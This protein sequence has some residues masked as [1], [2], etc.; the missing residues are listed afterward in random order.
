MAR[1]K[2]P[3]PGTFRPIEVP[4]RLAQNFRPI[5]VGGN[6]TAAPVAATV[7]KPATGKEED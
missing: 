4:V 5:Y 3:E 2:K 1:R 6:Q 7:E